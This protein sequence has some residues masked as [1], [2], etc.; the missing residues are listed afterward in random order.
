M[1]AI[2]VAESGIMNFFNSVVSLAVSDFD[3][4][5]RKNNLFLKNDRKINDVA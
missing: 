2:A 3:F 1:P 4:D 5:F